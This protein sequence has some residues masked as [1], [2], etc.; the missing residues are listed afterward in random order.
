MKPY[1]ETKLGKLYHGDCLE[2]MPEL[3][4][5]DLVLTDPPYSSGARQT[6]QLRARGAM[7]RNKKFQ[8]AWFGTDN[9]STAGF[10][11]FLRGC[12]IQSFN[13]MKPNTHFYMFIDWRNYP[14]LVNVL[15][16][17]GIRINNMIVWDKEHFGMGTNYRQQHELVIFGS[18]GPPK[19]C[20]YHNLPNILKSKR[21]KQD[22]HPT[23]KPVWLLSNFIGMSTLPGEV[24]IDF[25]IGSGTTAIACEKLN[26]RWIGIEISEE[27][28]EIAKQRI[29]NETRQL[30]LKGF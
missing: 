29:I 11:F 27:Y 17:A 9:C 30:K 2:I 3:E 7:I 8:N 28:C 1:Y 10:M 26:R 14:I 15:E 13:L 6:N 4:P 24:V 20:N 22:V 19:E 16:S 12:G 21:V 25:F 18:K 5:V 23:E